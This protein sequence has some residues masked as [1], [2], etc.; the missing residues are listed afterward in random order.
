MDAG[1]VPFL[2]ALI[3]HHDA[4]LKE[5]VCNCLAN[6]AR[7]TIDLAEVV[8]EAEIFPKIF[9]KLKDPDP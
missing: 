4:K 5:H 3:Q 8:S 2:S 7:H 9:Y 1:A 6:I